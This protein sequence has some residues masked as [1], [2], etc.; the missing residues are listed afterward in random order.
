MP[1]SRRP[2]AANT[3]L[4]YQDEAIL[5][6]LAR[7]QYLLSRQICRLLY[8]PNS[9]TYVQTR[10]KRLAEGGYCQ[11]LWLPKRGRYGS[12]PAVYTLA[13]R[14]IAHLLSSGSRLNRRYHPSEQEAR[15]LLFLQHT[16]DLNDFLI[17][18]ELLGRWRPEF[19]LAAML[20]ER[21]LKQHPVYVEGDAGKRTA[22]IPDA[23]LIYASRA[24]SR[25]AS[26]S[27]WTAA[28]RS[29][30][31]GARKS[32]TCWLTPTDPIRRPSKPDRSPL[33]WSQRLEAGA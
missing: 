29:R 24:A 19:Q 7:Y 22:V 12:A 27:S 13:R 33:R 21:E 1:V 16:L 3:I 18:A 2:L 17:S 32:P 8:S 23:W 15:S 5:R 26:R 4:S 31:A 14:G 28:L 20:H 25:S 11:R 9:I 6:C 30:S 10:L